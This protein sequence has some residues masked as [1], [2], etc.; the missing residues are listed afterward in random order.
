MYVLKA[1][2]C[3]PSLHI[4]MGLHAVRFSC[5]DRSHYHLAGWDGAVAVP[6]RDKCTSFRRY[7][8]RV[9]TTKQTHHDTNSRWRRRC[10]HA[11][12]CIPTYVF[13][14]NRC[15]HSYPNGCDVVTSS[16]LRAG[17]KGGDRRTD[18]TSASNPVLLIREQAALQHLI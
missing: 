16:R 2:R 3:A 15:S 12:M 9:Q 14:S 11:S 5:F 17:V 6:R 8:N 10:V 1:S 7:S 4:L 13:T 18:V